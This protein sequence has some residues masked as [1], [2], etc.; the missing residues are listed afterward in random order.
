MDFI[1]FDNE[2]MDT[3]IQGY[4]NCLQRLDECVGEI[5]TELQKSGKAEQTVVIFFSDHGAQMG[6]GKTAAYEGGVRVPCIIRWPGVTQAGKRTEALWSTI[7]LLPTLLDIA[8]VEIPDYLPGRS[9]EPLL[10]GDCTTGDYR[11]YLF[12]E[13]NAAS[14][15]LYYPQRT[16]RDDRYKLIL[17]QRHEALCPA[18][19]HYLRHVRSHWTGSPNYDELKTAEPRTQ[20]IYERFMHPDRIELYDL[21]TDPWEFTNRADDPALADVKARL[22]AAL[23]KW[24]VD[25]K[26]PFARPELER[27]HYEESQ[28]VI[29]AGRRTPVDGWDYVERMNPDN[30]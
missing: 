20:E 28:A 30:F 3:P 11:E 21:K 27:R 13:W 16:V 23:E 2:R 19:D 22:L 17:S 24:Q 15:A 1:A 6:R 26:D 25:T 12:T 7:D 8:R 9:T 4:Y 5:L 14:A 29:K 10:S 18:A